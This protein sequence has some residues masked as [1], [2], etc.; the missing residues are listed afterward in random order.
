MTT[1]EWI[2]ILTPIVVAVSIAYQ[3]YQSATV[4][5]A[6]DAAH[7][8]NDVKLDTIHGLVNGNMTEQKRVTMVQARRIAE[9]TLSPQDKAL[10]LDAERSYEDQLKRQERAV[11]EQLPTEHRLLTTDGP[12]IRMVLERLD[13]IEN[14]VQVLPCT[15]ARKCQTDPAATPTA[16]E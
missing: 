8:K 13:R 4:K 9:L 2:E 1:Q 16:K 6:L 3:K 14:L 10:A 5:N 15:L 7:A 12:A 11:I